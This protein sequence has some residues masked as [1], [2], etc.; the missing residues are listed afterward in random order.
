MKFPVRLGRLRNTRGGMRSTAR[1][2]S[3]PYTP[4]TGPSPDDPPPLE[5]TVTASSPTVYRGVRITFTGTVENAPEGVTLSYSWT[6]GDGA[7]D[8]QGINGLTPSCEYDTVGEKTVRLTVSYT[9]D[10]ETVEAFGE[11]TI[12]V[13]AIVVVPPLS[14]VADAGSDLLAAVNQGVSFDGSG[15]TSPSGGSLKYS[16]AFGDEENP[17]AVG[18]GVMPSYT[19]TTAGTKT[20]SLTVTDEDTGLSR[21]DEVTITVIDVGVTVIGTPR[22]VAVTP[23]TQVRFTGTVLD[24]PEGATLNYSWNFGGGAI[25]PRDYGLTASCQYTTTPGDRIVTLT[26]GVTIGEQ[27]VEV[28]GTCV[29]TVFKVDAGLPQVVAV[30]DTVDFTGTVLDAPEGATLSSSWTFRDGATSIYV[31]KLTASCS[32]TTA[33]DKTVKLTVSFTID[34]EL[35]E[36]SDTVKITV[37]ESQL[38]PHGPRRLSQLE[39]DAVRLVFGNSR[40]F[41][42][43]R[44]LNKIRIRVVSEIPGQPSWRGSENDGLITIAASRFQYTESLDHNSTRDNVD[45]FKP[46]N[47]SYLNTLIHE[48]AHWWQDDNDRY[49]DLSMQNPE[50]ETHRNMFDSDT[51]QNL[52]F[53]DKEQ[54]AS[55]AGTWF[56][57]GWQLKYRD[58]A[59]EPMINL[60]TSNAETS[61]GTVSRYSVIRDIPSA[62]ANSGYSGRW[63]PRESEET[64]SAEDLSSHFTALLDELRSH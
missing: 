49:D 1:S 32:Y 17:T 20:V 16:W 14:P 9:A 57:I 10:G 29:I 59:V 55:A 18:D 12:T 13:T 45:I 6:F 39:K 7:T 63:I 37:L 61:V 38:R 64:L 47:M 5:V 34:G 22:V 41:T 62:P 35:V 42:N 52:T 3:T 50:S 56:V 25:F 46:G 8:I 60:S 2:G 40:S 21:S 30:G 51:L 36:G 54:H 58:G 31:N 23:G 11:V 15:S 27:T 28:E 33:G 26:V 24:A 4:Y 53:E 48:C 43:E 44:I 19:Y